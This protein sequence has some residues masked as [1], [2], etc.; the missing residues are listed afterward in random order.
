MF[1][2]GGLF[3]PLLIASV[4]GFEVYNVFL[5]YVIIVTV[6]EVGVCWVIRCVLHYNPFIASLQTAKRQNVS[7][8]PVYRRLTLSF[9]VLVFS[10]PLSVSFNLSRIKEVI[11][12]VSHRLSSLFYSL[13]LDRRTEMLSP[14]GL[15]LCGEQIENKKGHLRGSFWCSDSVTNWS[16]LVLFS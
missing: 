7:E 8:G 6:F 14:K 3:G 12:R 9:R 10:S 16:T 5:P 13:D 15:F 1:L 2:R 11:N 4:V